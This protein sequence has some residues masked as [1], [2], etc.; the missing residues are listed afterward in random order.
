MQ[1]K[2]IQNPLPKMLP[3]LQTGKIEQTTNVGFRTKENQM[4]SYD[5]MKTGMTFLYYN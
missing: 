3:V 2:R 4:F 1:K 5:M